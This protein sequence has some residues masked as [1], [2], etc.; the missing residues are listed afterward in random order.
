MIKR[1]NRKKFG[2]NKQTV[3]LDQLSSRLNNIVKI[4]KSGEDYIVIPPNSDRKFIR[5]QKVLKFTLGDTIKEKAVE[6]LLK[7]NHERGGI[8]YVTPKVLNRS[9][10]DE[11]GVFPPFMPKHIKVIEV[12]KTNIIKFKK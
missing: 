11:G 1:N 3:Y 9:N 2:I 6:E 12:K 4:D 8:A 5:N 7:R 10:E